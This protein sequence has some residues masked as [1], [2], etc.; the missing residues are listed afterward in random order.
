MRSATIALL[1]SHLT[2]A[3]A[4]A[5]AATLMPETV[6]AWNLHVAATEARVE[7]E[8]SSWRR[9]LAIAQPHGST[10]DVPGGTVSHWRGSIF[11]PG[12]QL[13]AL[14]HRL[15]H[16]REEG[17]HQEDVLAVRVLDRAP[18][19]LNL[20]IRMTRTK[21]VTV[22]YDTEHRIDYR[23]HGPARTSS[24]SIASRIVELHDDGREKAPG[25]DR[26]FLWRMNSYWRYEQ[27]AGGVIVDLES[28][29]LSR[30][31]PLGLGAL[32]RPMINRVA[33]ES[34]TRTLEHIRHTY[35]A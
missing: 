6:T 28:V 31:V 3:P 32:V 18:D 34:M 29:T 11:L 20:F 23:R 1:V 21:I 10:I 25:N 4:I 33:R 2:L 7:R 14:L 8:L 35:A 5:N 27:T 30:S 16:P 26:G 15:Q 22:T 24:R 17:P 13:D 12:V 9:N 19:R